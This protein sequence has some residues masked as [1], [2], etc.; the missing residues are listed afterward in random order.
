MFVLG[1]D[2]GGIVATMADAA[3]AG[4]PRIVR[5]DDEVRWRGQVLT[6]LGL[7]ALSYWI[8]VW[9][10]DGPVE[11]LPAGVIFLASLVFAFVLGAITSRRR[12]AHGMLTLRPPRSVVHET[13]ADGRERRMRAATIM[14]LGVGTLLV[15][16]TLISEIGGTAALVAGVGLGLGMVDRLEARRWAMAEDERDSRIFLMIRP[17]A[18]IA[19]MGVQDAYALPRGRSGD[20]HDEGPAAT[21]M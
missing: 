5:A 6:S 11:P 14:F 15:L 13:I 19:G 10:F 1:V 2:S 21:F 3:L 7:A 9:L 16:D 4:L 8:I 12:F 17:N 20:D 18:L